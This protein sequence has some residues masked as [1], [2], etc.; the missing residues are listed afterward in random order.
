[1]VLIKDDS[2]ERREKLMRTE[3]RHSGTGNSQKCF[4]N[5]WGIEAGKKVNKSCLS[6]IS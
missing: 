6:T 5:I 2:V 3:I 4:L 1:M